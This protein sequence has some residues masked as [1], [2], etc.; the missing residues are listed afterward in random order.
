MTIKDP[1][2]AEVVALLGRITTSYIG[3][4]ETAAARQ[5][6]TPQQAKALLALDEALPMRRV[7]E[8]VGAEPS[9][10]TG[11]VDRL[12]ARGLVERRADPDDRR[13]KLIAATD[14]GKSVAAE[15]RGDLRF[16]SDPLVALTEPQRRTLRDLLQLMT[17]SL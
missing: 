15:L 11:I 10:M 13:V 14:A 6:L 17:E 4:Y 9:N 8:R 16:A 7:A 1:L 5:G 3:E 12:Q 2:S